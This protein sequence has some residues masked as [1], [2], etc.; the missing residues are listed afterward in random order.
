MTPL[1]RLGNVQDVSNAALF[2]CSESAA[3]ITGITLVVDGGLWLAQIGKPP[4]LAVRRAAGF[5]RG[6]GRAKNMRRSPNMNS[7]VQQGDRHARVAE[8]IPRP[9]V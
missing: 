2:L 8:P 5:D 3:F 4:P 6:R 9:M 1:G 7:P